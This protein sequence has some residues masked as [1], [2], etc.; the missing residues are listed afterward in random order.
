M[1][2][3]HLIPPTSSMQSDQQLYSN[4]LINMTLTATCSVHAIY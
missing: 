4:S 3:K 1:Q 2:R